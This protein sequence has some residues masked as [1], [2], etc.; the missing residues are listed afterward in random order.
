MT[1]VTAPDRNFLAKLKQ[2]A[3]EGCTPKEAAT[4]V[5]KI[6]GEGGWLE[7]IQKLTPGRA[8]NVMDVLE[9][10]G[11]VSDWDGEEALAD[12][13]AAQ[14]GE[15]IAELDPPVSAGG[16]GTGG[17]PPS[18]GGSGGAGHGGAGAGEDDG[19]PGAIDQA[20]ADLDRNIGRLL[21]T[22][23]GYATPAGGLPSRPGNGRTGGDIGDLISAMS[24][25]L[26]QAKTPAAAG[27]AAATTAGRLARTKG[28][29][30]SGHA[31]PVLVSNMLEA[32]LPGMLDYAESV[33]GSPSVHR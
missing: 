27:P 3:K 18:A 9:E 26:D 8:K 16:V 4:A 22:E 2:A 12:V 32:V 5:Q 10:R 15:A 11:F 20:V 6:L 28:V 25:L 13:L 33:G 1:T 31:V 29:A 7:R 14:L 24:K 17:V 30:L 23:T 21:G 19:A